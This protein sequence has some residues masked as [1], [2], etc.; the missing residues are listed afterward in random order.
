MR[1]GNLP[2]TPGRVLGANIGPHDNCS[3]HVTLF[4]VKYFIG[5]QVP[6]RFSIICNYCV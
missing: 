2:G 6:M 3:N 1:G 5:G 4:Q